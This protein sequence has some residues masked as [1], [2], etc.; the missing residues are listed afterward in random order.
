MKHHVTVALAIMA[1]WGI[2][3]V[4]AQPAANPIEAHLAAAKAAAGFDF[5][6]LLA[7]NC[8]APQTAEGP[9][10]APPPPPDRASWY[11]EP[12]KVFDDLYFV[13][14][15]FHSAW[16]MTSREGIILLDTLYDY[17]SEEAIVGGL[18][19]LGLDPA[20]VKYVIVT[21]A[22]LD[23]DGGAKLMQDRFGS[24]IIM[25]GPDWDTIEGSVNRYPNGKPRRD[26]V[27]FDGQ[28]VVLGDAAVTLV[29]TPGH[30]AGTVS[31]FFPVTDNGTRLM[32]AYSGGTAFNF[33]NDVPH[34][35]TYIYTQRKMAELAAGLNA[36]VIMS[37]HSEF[38][39]AVTKVKMLAARG[40]GEPHPFDLGRNAV[41]RYFKT[42]D[43]C[44]QAARLKLL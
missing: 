34:F 31:M 43:E 15:K 24:R 27:A 13:G 21:H 25:G 33:P 26:M 35:D 40:P 7:R 6:G 39:N 32:V 3:D 16:A 14:T 18:R 37:N 44:A 29:L 10:V 23:H 9:D 30:T 17:A 42:S 11:T 38:D 2:A 12:A 8:I 28:K 20:T 5:P 36:S 41:L 22:H 4:V 1:T 19:K